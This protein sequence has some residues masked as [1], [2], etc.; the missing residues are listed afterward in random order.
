MGVVG[1]GGGGGVKAGS[2]AVCVA[3]CAG[4]RGGKKPFSLG[5]GEGKAHLGRSPWRFYQ[6]LH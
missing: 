3:A 4:A 5:R 2:G 6:R 1:G